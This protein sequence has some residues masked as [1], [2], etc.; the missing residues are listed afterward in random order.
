MYFPYHEAH[1]L[2]IHRPLSLSLVKNKYIFVEI[3]NILLYRS[4]VGAGGSQNAHMRAEQL[5]DACCRPPMLKQ[6]IQESASVSFY[7]QHT[8]YYFFLF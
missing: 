2:H 4:F 5:E 1:Y 3:L 7:T 6:E 8:N